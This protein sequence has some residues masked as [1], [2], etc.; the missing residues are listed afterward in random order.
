MKRFLS[1]NAAAQLRE[2]LTFT[3]GYLEGLDF[4]RYRSLFGE[5]LVEVIRSLYLLKN[6]YFLAGPAI[7]VLESRSDL[8]RPDDLELVSSIEKS[9]RNE[10]EYAD[11]SRDLEEHPVRNILGR[12][13]NIF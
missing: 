2:S 13:K 6:G 12:L 5:T 4:Q 10:E 9:M 8:F 1:E 11:I 7:R 3:L